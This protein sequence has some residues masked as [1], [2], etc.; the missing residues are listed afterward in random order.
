MLIFYSS[1]VA[2]FILPLVSSV[3][4]RSVSFC[5]WNVWLCLTSI[6]AMLIGLAPV[7]VVKKKR[8]KKSPEIHLLFI[9]FF[10]FYPLSRKKKPASS[11]LFSLKS[12]TTQ[13]A[14]ITP[15]LSRQDIL[16]S[17]MNKN[18][19]PREILQSMPYHL[20]ARHENSC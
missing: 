14:F 11:N 19:I 20:A 10:F 16:A 4:F 6:Y 18:L 7:V 13:M 2:S 17:R 5:C 8:K 9:F 3:E 15:E 12:Y 1:P